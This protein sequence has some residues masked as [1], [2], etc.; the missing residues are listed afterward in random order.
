M[1]VCIATATK[2]VIQSAKTATTDN[3]YIGALTT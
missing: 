3:Y 1:L 2:N